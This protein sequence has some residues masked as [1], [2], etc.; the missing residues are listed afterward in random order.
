L[1]SQ[2][3]TSVHIIWMELN[4]NGLLNDAIHVLGLSGEDGGI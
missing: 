1:L 3:P 2:K 4:F